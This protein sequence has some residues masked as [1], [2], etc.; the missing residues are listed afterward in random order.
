MGASG[1]RYYAPYQSDI[2]QAL[3]ELRNAVFESGDYYTDAAFAE[4]MDED[5]VAKYLPPDFVDQFKA[6][7]H[8]LRSKSNS[9][10]P[11]SIAELLEM[12]GESGT[13]CI[14]DIEGISSEPQFGMA[15]PL[16]NSQLQSFFGTDQPNRDMIEQKFEEIMQFRQR[17]EATYIIVYEDGKPTEIYFT[18]Y[19]GD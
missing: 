9:Q 14:L 3:Q 17:W 11:S 15:T 8:S 18:G 10:K 5:E 12:N 2:N 7:L 13:H 6:A 1:W 4:A 19:S 16:I